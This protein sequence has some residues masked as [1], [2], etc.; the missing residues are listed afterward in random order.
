ME[1]K[2]ILY[3]YT[4]EE[5]IDSIKEKGLLNIFGLI[6]FTTE[7]TTEPSVD[8]RG[9]RTQARV[10]V[11][12][13]NDFHK[14][15]DMLKTKDGY[16]LLSSFFNPKLIHHIGANPDNWYVSFKE[17]I[18]TKDILKYEIQNENGYYNV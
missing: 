1:T 4:S 5:V 6:F 15:S 7:T 18:D 9:L 11:K 10:S 12:L 8:F 3:H 16:N 13:T 2:K 17:K 14:V